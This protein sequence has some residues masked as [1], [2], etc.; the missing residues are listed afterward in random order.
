MCRETGESGPWCD[1]DLL[2]AETLQQATEVG[3]V[4]AVSIPHQIRRGG[5]VGKRFADLLSRPGSGRMIG[6][7]HMHDAPAIVGE[8]HQ[9]EQDPE[10]RS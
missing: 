4:D 7:I 6:D 9:D 5:V 1:D 8:D 10:G 2:G 3:F